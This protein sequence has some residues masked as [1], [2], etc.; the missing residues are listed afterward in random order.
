MDAGGMKGRYCYGVNVNNRSG[1]GSSV[2]ATY[3]PSVN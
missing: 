3:A 2:P 1:D